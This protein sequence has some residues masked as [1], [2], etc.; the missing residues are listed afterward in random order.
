[1]ERKE[2]LRYMEHP[3]RLSPV[4]GAGLQE[5]VNLYPW[6]TA[7]RVLLARC[8]EQVDPILALHLLRRPYP[9]LLLAPLKKGD[10]SRRSSA[11]LVDDFLQL[12]DVRIRPA[13][14]KAREG[15]ISALSVEEDPGLV[16][17]ELAEIYRMQGLNGKARDIY[18]KLSLLYP[19]K[20]VYFAEL[21]AEIEHDMLACS[22]DAGPHEGGQGAVA[23]DSGT[24]DEGDA[25]R[26]NRL[27]ALNIPR[28]I[29]PEGD[30]ERQP[31]M[32][33]EPLPGD[34]ES[35]NV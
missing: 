23:D 26:V 31:G 18:R 28:D 35:E 27:A 24:P 5:I 11:E 34:K 17:E 21:I 10:F 32:R 16:S 9:S 20:C 1:M 12:S 7:A 22:P 6:F 2:F 3:D 33:S 4:A 15:D 25:G 8:R 30:A 29:S 14:G 19:E 13:E